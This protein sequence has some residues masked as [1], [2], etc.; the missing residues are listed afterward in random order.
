VAG[1]LISACGSCKWAGRG[2]EEGASGELLRWQ[3]TQ[4]RC[5]RKEARQSVVRAVASKEHVG[6]AVSC[7]ASS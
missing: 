6:D 7:R 4:Q 2:G 1:R 5:K 3:Q